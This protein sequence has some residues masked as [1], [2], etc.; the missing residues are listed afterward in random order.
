MIRTGCACLVALAMNALAAV[1]DAQTVTVNISADTVD[2]DWQT[3]TIADLPGPDGN[4]S[5][6]EAIIATDNTP[7]HQ[8]IGFA[9]PQ[10][11]WQLQFLYPGRAVLTS[12]TGFFF[13]AN[14][15]VT[16]DGTTQTAFTGDTHPDGWEVVIY[17]NTLYLNGDQ[18]TL[19]GFDSTSVSVSGSACQVE[20]NTGTMNITLFGG[21]G[22]VITGNQ[23]GT[24]KIDR[25]S[26]NKLVGNTVSR[27]RVLG[28]GPTVVGNV[29][30]G[31]D[32]ADRNFIT[33][34]GTINGE[35]LPGGTTIQLFDSSDTVIE[36][37]W[38]GTTPDGLA[39]GSLASTVGI[40]FEGNNDNTT[41]RN[42]R[43]AGIL[44]H[45]QGPH[46]SGQ[47]FGWAIL[48]GGSGTGIELV[49]NTI[50]LDANDMP[51]LGSVWG[52]DVG[53]VITRPSDVNGIRI[54]GP[55]PGEGNVIAGHILNGVTIG[56]D[57]DAVRLSGNAIHDNGWLGID[58][59][60]S[61][62]G[63]GVT[64]NDP[65]DTDNGGNGLQNHPVVQSATL[66]GAIVHVQGELHSSPLDGFMVE[67]FASAGCDGSGSGEGQLFLGSVSVNT[68]A[69]G[70]GG[71]DVRLP[72][73]PAVAG[74]WVVTATA[75]LDSNGATS[76]FSPCVPLVE[77]LCQQDIGFGGPG[78]ATLE[79]CGQPLDTG[80]TA[81][82]WVANAP[83]QAP[84]LLLLG[85][86]QNPTPFRGG[87]LVPLP[88]AD[89]YLVMTDQAGSFSTSVAGGGGPATVFVQA[90]IGDGGQPF[91]VGLT[92]ALSVTIGS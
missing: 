43:I 23:G 13:R 77:A 41:I 5:L 63:Y 11:D 52:I 38:I 56:H 53:N 28:G 33:G 68:D 7:G 74:G 2:I 36:N 19:E 87:T 15:E 69:T 91:G 71:F 58:L 59:I 27:V 12:T 65:G 82:L 39:Q 89:A 51:T 1:A 9:I 70:A 20:G 81:T 55:Q 47:L 3:A 45:G 85:L 30:G 83:S 54:G 92:N 90:V 46:H 31:P 73:P 37:N 34:Y 79:L 42:N 60:P 25:S 57:V 16:I 62:Y 35:G 4:I 8:T 49:G 78:D 18:S 26:H 86:A 24:I 75:T 66:E 22:S 64:A 80:N 29:I 61:G 40:G 76:E 48:I 72:A 14:D 44:G 50:G 6:S 88:V 67:L 10:S 84:A 21:S 32:P 17:S